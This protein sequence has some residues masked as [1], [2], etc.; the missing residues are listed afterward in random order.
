VPPPGT[1][2][3]HDVT[4]LLI[5][6]E[7]T[8]AC[9]RNPGSDLPHNPCE[10]LIDYNENTVDIWDVTD[11][12]DPIKLSST[13][14]EN[15]RYTQSGWWTADKR[16]VFIQDE[17]DEVERDLS[18]TL[19]I[20]KLDDLKNPG[21]VKVSWMG[22]TKAI[23]HN[24]FA[25]GDIYYMSNYL[26][27]LTVLDISDPERAEQIAFFDTAPDLDVNDFGGAWGV[28]PYLPSGTIVVSDIERGLFVLRL[29]SGE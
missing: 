6:D 1:F 17:L 19:R 12:L 5:D 26:R 9:T 7:R 14:Y 3:A 24:G 23:D 13:P 8:E 25:K 2:Y 4:T 22:P 29:R 10:I 18:T 28:Y 27:G 16:Y 21:P 20:I 11:K 15:A